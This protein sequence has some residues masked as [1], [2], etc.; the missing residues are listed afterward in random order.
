MWFGICYTNCTALIRDHFRPYVCLYTLPPWKRTNN[1]EKAWEILLRELKQISLAHTG[2]GE[3]SPSNV[4]GAGLP[5]WLERRICDP[6]NCP[7][8]G[9]LPVQT[10]IS[11][12]VPP[13]CYCSSTK[14][15]R[16]FCQTC[17]W[18]VTD[19]H[20]CTLPMYLW[21]KWHSKLVHGCMVYIE[22][23]PRRQQFHLAP[24][25]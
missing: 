22:H 6:K 7:F 13:P 4:G 8:H 21:M 12:S 2:M 15:S 11:V 1:E 20:T 24:T 16:S 10:L 3:F 19:K 17:R 25:M 14:R 9:Q 23:A 18:Q 5:Q